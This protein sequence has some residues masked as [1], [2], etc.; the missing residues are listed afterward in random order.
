M[1]RI[2]K[3]V[4]ECGAD[5]IALHLSGAVTVP[6]VIG[7]VGLAES[8]GH[9]PC[10][11]SESNIHRVQKQKFHVTIGSP[12][13]AQKLISSAQHTCRYLNDEGTEAESQSVGV[14]TYASESCATRPQSG[15]CL[16]TGPGPF[17]A[18]PRLVRVVDRFCLP[19]KADNMNYSSPLDF[20]VDAPATTFVVASEVASVPEL[21]AFKYQSEP[22]Y[23]SI[24]TA[25]RATSRVEN[26]RQSAPQQ[27]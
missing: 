11:S 20:A 9:A 22:N 16:A 14:F 6:S 5:S 21:S 10:V 7:G 19:L 13:V 2:W 15:R 27:A 23:F 4:Q 24:T 3:S 26:H 12:S 25:P 18:N 17:A 1:I 8:P